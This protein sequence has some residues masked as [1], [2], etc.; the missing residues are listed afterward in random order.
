MKTHIRMRF[1]PGKPGYYFDAC[2]ECQNDEREYSNKA[3]AFS[4]DFGK[5]MDRWES[6]HEDKT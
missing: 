1:Y 2:P 4:E 5:A 6:D 3:R